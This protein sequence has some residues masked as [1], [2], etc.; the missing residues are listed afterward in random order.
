MATFNQD[1]RKAYNNV[2]QREKE[3]ARSLREAGYKTYRDMIRNAENSADLYEA[4]EDCISSAEAFSLL[5]NWSEN[6][7]DTLTR[8][9]ESLTSQANRKARNE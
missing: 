6:M 5:S 3:R 2:V 9:A 7:S 8:Q 1:F 4:A